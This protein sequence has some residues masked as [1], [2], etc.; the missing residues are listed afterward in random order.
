MTL[1][2]S[3]DRNPLNWTLDEIV[4]EVK[5]RRIS[6]TQG[7]KMLER[8]KQILDEKFNKCRN[9]VQPRTVVKPLN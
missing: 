3:R 6:T 5:E 2:T 9:A 4:K 1:K 7:L 8:K